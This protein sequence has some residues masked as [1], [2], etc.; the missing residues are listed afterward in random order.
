[1][2]EGTA[3]GPGKALWAAAMGDRQENTVKIGMKLR[4]IIRC[5]DTE[6]VPL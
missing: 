1:M 2:A 6:C 4:K 3:E 5:V